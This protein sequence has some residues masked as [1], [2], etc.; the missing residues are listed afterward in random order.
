MRYS[1]SIIVSI[2][3]FS[4]MQEIPSS[5]DGRLTYTA[6]IFLQ[7]TTTEGI[8]AHPIA[9]A[10]VT[11]TSA[12]YSGT[13]G[14]PESFTQTTDSAGLAVFEALAVDRYFVYV[15][16]KITTNARTIQ[17]SSGK[18][19]DLPS[20]S[21]GIDSIEV[22]MTELSNIVI[23][24]IYYCGPVNRDNYVYDQ[25]VELYN[26]SDTT[27]YLDGMFLCHVIQ[28]P[29][30][31]MERIT[32][33]QTKNIFKFPGEPK[34]GT[35]YPIK[36]GEFIVIA[37]D[38]I[39]HT[40]YVEKSINL[41]EADWEFFNP[42]SGD[43]DNPAPNVFNILPEKASD[44][45]IGLNS[46]GIILSDGSEWSWGEISASGIQ[47]IHIPIKT[48]L[49]GVECRSNPD[50][51]KSLTRRIDAGSAGRGIRKYS[52]YSVERRLAGMDTNN[53]SVD[54]INLPHPT[55]GYQNN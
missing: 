41:S 43:L 47:Y 49:D 37:Q 18:T 34:S 40:L 50:T 42:Y 44:F 16:K 19:V 11:L 23:N 26:R 15:D 9:G 29:H 36:P 24:E 4:C 32:F 5:V 27:V 22:Q 52:G 46:N 51:P 45:L 31:D 39:D 53:S 12:N 38:A 28:I 48:I 55:P 6:F 3:L 14:H 7:D 8:S 20:A 25:Y 21:T 2:S 17:I 54:F 33:V 30:P 10:T 35:S 13:D 1:V